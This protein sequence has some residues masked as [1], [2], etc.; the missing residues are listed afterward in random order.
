[1]YI[2]KDFLL[3]KQ[4]DLYDNVQD[5]KVRSLFGIFKTKNKKRLEI[6]NK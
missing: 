5:Y 3:P 4:I 6:F 1:M 2:M